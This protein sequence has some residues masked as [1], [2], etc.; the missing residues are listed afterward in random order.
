MAGE[1]ELGACIPTIFQ[2]NIIWMIIFNALRILRD[3]KYGVLHRAGRFRT[4][5]NRIK[6]VSNIMYQ[7]GE[8]HKGSPCGRAKWGTESCA[9]N[10]ILL[11]LRRLMSRRTHPVDCLELACSSQTL[12][13]T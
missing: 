12:S 2:R 9:R 3:Y 7:S 1:E 6:E 5:M 8:E 11:G 4:V 10:S 13:S